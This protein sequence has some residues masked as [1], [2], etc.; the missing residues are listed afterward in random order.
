MALR[1][2]EP[3]IDAGPSRRLGLAIEMAE[4]GRQMRMQ[5]F[6]REHP[7]ATEGDLAGFMRRWYREASGAE[8]GDRSRLFR[9]RD[10]R[11]D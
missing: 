10:A 2:G 6:R 7:D 8:D 11:D 9:V 4:L 5:R 1:A 3:A